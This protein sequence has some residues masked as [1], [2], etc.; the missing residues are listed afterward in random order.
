MGENERSKTQVSGYLVLFQ[1]RVGMPQRI[2][3]AHEHAD[4]IWNEAGHAT[5]CEPLPQIG[6]KASSVR[7]NCSS[8]E[9]NLDVARAEKVSAEY[10]PPAITHSRFALG[11]SLADRPLGVHGVIARDSVVIRVE[12]E[13][14]QVNLLHNSEGDFSLVD[15]VHSIRA[16]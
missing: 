9:K 7:G 8:G 16:F 6:I 11:Y 1:S 3:R 13:Y 10:M 12:E 4:D 15:E 14:T 5:G 2:E